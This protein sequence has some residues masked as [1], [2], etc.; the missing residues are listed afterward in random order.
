M[1]TIRDPIKNKEVRD[2]IKIS[3]LKLLRIIIKTIIRIRS[4]LKGVTLYYAI[5]LEKPKFYIKEPNKY[6]CNSL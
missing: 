5:I 3:I 2:I 4:G 1:V 6:N